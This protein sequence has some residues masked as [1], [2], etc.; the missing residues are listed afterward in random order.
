MKAGVWLQKEVKGDRASAAHVQGSRGGVRDRV[1]RWVT[2]RL[3][4]NFLARP[5]SGWGL[6]L[7]FSKKKLLILTLKSVESK[8]VL[9]FYYKIGA[10]FLF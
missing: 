8:M 1:R 7:V 6:S 3:G 5:W 2:S 10:E 4:L 9:I